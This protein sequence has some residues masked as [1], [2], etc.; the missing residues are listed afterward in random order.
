MLGRRIIIVS[1]AEFLDAINERLHAMSE[2]QIAERDALIRNWLL[3]KKQLDTAKEAESVMRAQIV[4]M[5][6]DPNKEKGTENLELGEGYKLK[7]VKKETAKIDKNRIDSALEAI[8]A[9]G[10][11]AKFFAE[12]LFKWTP[13]LSITEWNDIKERAEGGDAMCQAIVGK[14]L[15][16]AT[17]TPIVTFA[18]GMPS[19]E[20]IEPKAK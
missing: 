17:E 1:A 6:F 20:F 14:L 10:E 9:L 8:E 2:S 16:D 3:S 5:Y 19:L 11:R 7:C 18:P 4:A 12:R 15:G 13:D